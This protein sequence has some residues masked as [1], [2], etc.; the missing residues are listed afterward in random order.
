MDGAIQALRTCIVDDVHVGVRFAELLDTLANR[1]RSSFVRMAP[2]GGIAVSRGAS[3]GIQPNFQPQMGPPSV[4]GHLGPSQ[5]SGFNPS[6]PSLTGGRATPTNP[7]YG[8]STESYDPGSSNISIMPPPTFA[9][10]GAFDGSSMGNG[11]NSLGPPGMDEAS[12]YMHDWLALPL[13]PLL[14]TYGVDVNQTTHGPDVGGLDLL[15]ILLSGM[16]G[17]TPTN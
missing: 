7:L 10:N 4:P 11:A 12:L 17:S 3:P 9:A 6:S 15:D 14:N 13:D 16:N 2:K 1:I 5:W 8:I